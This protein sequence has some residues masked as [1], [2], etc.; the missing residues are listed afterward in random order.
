MSPSF[1]KWCIKP[2]LSPA[3]T[4]SKPV[5]TSFSCFF[6][7]DS[8]L[9]PVKKLAEF[10]SSLGMCLAKPWPFLMWA[11]HS[12]P[13]HW[14]RAKVRSTSTWHWRGLQLKLVSRS[15][16]K[17][18]RSFNFSLQWKSFLIFFF[19]FLQNCFFN[20]F[21]HL[22]KWLT[23]PLQLIFELFKGKTAQ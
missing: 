15:R 18:N 4:C 14:A 9:K 6:G 3:K 19:C 10:L 13:D 21:N 2:A 8:D 20:L 16:E 22:L 12:G 1:C 17:K 11:R 5:W 7:I 23:I